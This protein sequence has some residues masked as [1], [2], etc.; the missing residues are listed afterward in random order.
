[1]IIAIDG[2]A[3]AGKGTLARRI[4][5]HYGLTYLD[6]G[7]LYRATGL[8]LMQAGHDPEDAGRA[9][10]AARNLDLALMEHPDLR[11][12]RAGEIASI[13]AA[14]PQVRAALLDVQR[15]VAASRPG[16]VLDGR[17]IGT[18]VCPDA[19]VKIFVDASPQVRAKRRWKEWRE[20]GE[21]ADYEDILAQV[22]A[23][24]ARDRERAEAPLKPAE[25]AH[26]LDTSK[27]DIEAAFR[28]AR[29]II[30]AR[31]QAGSGQRGR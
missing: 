4:A 13:V 30:D 8:A 5:Q 28:A 24:D 7:A 19:D 29:Q 21:E 6:T 12:A 23:R 2:P 15:Q 17:D 25:D 18:V 11:S 10:A 26:L 3:A 22:L 16:A 14:I 9:E 31:I 27:L 20:A 1:M